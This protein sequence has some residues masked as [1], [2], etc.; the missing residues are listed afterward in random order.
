RKCNG[1]CC[2]FSVAVPDGAR[3]KADRPA[4]IPGGG[5]R[6]EADSNLGSVSM[7]CSVRLGR[8]LTFCVIAL[9]G[10]YLAMADVPAAAGTNDVGTTEREEV[11]VTARKRGEER[12]QDIPTAI[13]AF[14][15]Q[16]LDKMGVRDFTDFAY[17]VPG[18][19]FN[20]IGA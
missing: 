3:E 5:G 1:S 19:T 6:S 12:V 11:L 4:W 10:A 13:T 9:G 20:D 14:G 18:L 2:K 7:S 15:A 17:Q 16:T 8:L